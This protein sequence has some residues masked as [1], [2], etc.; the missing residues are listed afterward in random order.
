MITVEKRIHRG[1]AEMMEFKKRDPRTFKTL[2]FKQLFG[3]YQYIVSSPK[4]KVS[5]AAIHNIYNK[6]GWEIYCLEGDLFEDVINCS[7]QKDAIK[8]AKEF[9]K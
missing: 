9:L 3:K 5:C 2:H 1:Y 7:S 6:L 4:G 8:K